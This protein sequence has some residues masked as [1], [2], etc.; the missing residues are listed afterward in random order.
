MEKKKDGKESESKSHC[1]WR[2]DTS[3]KRGQKKPF[4]RPLDG[5]KFSRVNHSRINIAE[6]SKI[7]GMPS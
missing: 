7:H 4:P 5:Y 2:G 1:F 6:K 3:R